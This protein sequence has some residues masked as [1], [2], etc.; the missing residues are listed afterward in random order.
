MFTLKSGKLYIN[1]LKKDNQ[2]G[3]TAASKTV[4]RPISF[5]ALSKLLGKVKYPLGTS[6]VK[7]Y[8]N[9]SNLKYKNAEIIEKR[10]SSF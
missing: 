1:Y 10:L 8:A 5:P 6:E 4:T 7:F 2:Y 9:R 3:N